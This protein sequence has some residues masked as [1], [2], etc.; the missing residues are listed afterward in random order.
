MRL[1]K[2]Y[3]WKTQSVIPKASWYLASLLEASHRLSLELLCAL[4]KLLDMA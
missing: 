1:G 2:S 3:L 4:F